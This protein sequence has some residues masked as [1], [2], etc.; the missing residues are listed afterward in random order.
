VGR[1][2]RGAGNLTGTARCRGLHKPAE[3]ARSLAILTQPKV[4]MNGWKSYMQVRSVASYSGQPL[5]MMKYSLV[6]ASPA[7]VIWHSVF[8]T[9]QLVTRVLGACMF[10][11]VY[12]IAIYQAVFD[13]TEPIT[14]DKGKV[15]DSS[16]TALT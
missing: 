4:G 2:R 10:A 8:L 12:S 14:S 6:S 11:K 9:W 15:A 16:K 3:H 7:E 1:G 5:F 13:S